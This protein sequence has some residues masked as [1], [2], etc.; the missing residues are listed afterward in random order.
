M[1]FENNNSEATRSLIFQKQIFIGKIVSGKAFSDIIHSNYSDFNIELL[2][3]FANTVNMSRGIYEFLSVNI[4]G[5]Y[6]FGLIPFKV[7][8]NWLCLTCGDY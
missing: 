1:Y 5:K 2:E 8:I 6:F 3:D 4:R 7:L